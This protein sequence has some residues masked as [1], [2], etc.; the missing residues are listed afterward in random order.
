ML[1]FTNVTVFDGTRK[2]GVRTVS[3]A[4]DRIVDLHADP[5]DPALRGATRIDGQGATLLPGLIDAHTHLWAE[6][7]T[8]QSAV[9]GVTTALDMFSPPE[10]TPAW[11]IG[12]PGIGPVANTRTAGFPATVPGGHGTEYGIGTPAITS[13]EQAAAFVTARLADGAD[14]IKI[15]CDSV[16]GSAYSLSPDVIRAL[17]DAAH[18]QGVLALAHATIAKDAATAIDAGVDA[19]MHVPV[20][21]MTGLTPAVL[22]PTLATL[23]AGFSTDGPDVLSSPGLRGLIDV[24]AE[25]NL[26]QTWRIPPN[27]R[28]E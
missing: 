4:G 16:R 9:F 12:A 24:D 20:D 25:D 27:W 22:V 5:A 21:D 17:V 14:Y 8:T 26:S 18:D 3:V 11:R 1:L 7:A 6:H 15:I 2:L 28:Y 10:L 13:A 23:R 19:L